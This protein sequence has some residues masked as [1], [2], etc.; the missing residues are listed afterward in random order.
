METLRKTGIKIIGDMPWGTHFCQF[1]KTKDDLIDILVPYFKTGLENNE[2]CMW[3][4]SEPLPKEKAAEALKKSLPDSDN[5]IKKRQIEI[6]PYDEW[7]LKDGSFKSERVLSGWVEK[8]NKAL[9]RRYEGLRLTGNTF[10]LEKKDWISFTDYEEAVNNII[11]QY[12][13]LALCSY[14][15]DKCNATDILDVVSNHEFALIRS[16]KKWQLFENYKYKEARDALITHRK[17][18]EEVLKES[19]AKYRNIL[20]TANEGI[21]IS[22]SDGMINFSNSK[23]AQMLGYTEK[24]LLGKSSMELLLPDDYKFGKE[25]I[26]KRKKGIKE[27]YERK[28]KHKDGSYIWCLISGTPIIDKK[29]NYTGNLGMFIDITEQ[30]KMEEKLNYLSSFPELNPMPICE[31]DNAGN[32]QYLNTAIKRIFP[33]IESSGIKHPYLTG[34]DKIFKSWEISEGNLLTREVKVKNNYFEQIITMTKE[35]Q[36]IR[37]YGHDITKRKLAEDNI[38]LLNQSL[39]QRTLGLEAANKELEAF[40]YS[41]SHDLRT[42]LRAIDGFSKILLEEYSGLIDDEGRRLFKIIGTNIK[43]MGQLI[44]DL[45]ALSHLGR[46]EIDYSKIIMEKIVSSAIEELRPLSEDRKI[47]FE[48]KK[49]P[50]AYGDPGMIRQ[51]WVN[52]LSNAIKFTKPKKK[53]IIGIGGNSDKNMTVYYIKDNGVGFNMQYANKLFGIFQRLHGQEEFEGTGIGLAIVQQ[54]IKKHGGEVWARGEILKGAEFYFSLPNRTIT[55]L[56][57]TL[58][59]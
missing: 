45:L 24:E 38:I 41:V 47:D 32:L 33:D 3:I 23:I 13:M 1:Y 4:T 42:P 43:R 22:D 56:E 21:L 14:C 35:S 29:G 16:E 19:E 27:N 39:A 7:Y 34:I 6:I 46:K 15:L 53:A 12:K 17:E 54:I 48:I 50:A 37:I 51:V 49:M 5:Y 11:G 55:N 9:S 57:R 40:S 30:K 59:D 8:L 31:I 44:D 36:R 58:N 52:L 18:S 2:Y 28:L 20:E 25:I 10:W 26:E